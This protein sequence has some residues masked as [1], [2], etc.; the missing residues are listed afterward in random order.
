MESKLIS[1]I[2]GFEKGGSSTKIKQSVHPTLLHKLIKD[3]HMYLD[4]L[5]GDIFS[6]N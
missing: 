1:V 4:N 3:Y 5:S 6:Y 2:N